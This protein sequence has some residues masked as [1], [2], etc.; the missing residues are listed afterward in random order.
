MHGR[1]YTGTRAVRLA[2]VDRNGR[3]RLDALARFL[4]DVAIEDVQETGW[5][6]PGHLWFV[7]RI[8]V[9]VLAPF[10][11]DRDVVLT[12][13]CSSLAALAA[14]RRWSVRGDRGGHAE[15]DSVWIHLGP[16][17]RPERIENFGVYAESA[18]GRPA[19]TRFEVPEPAADA[20]VTAWPLRAAD[21]D[22]HGHVNNAVHWQAVEHALRLHGFDASRPLVAELDYRDP[23][24]LGDAVELVISGGEP[25]LAA[26]RVGGVTRAAARVTGRGQLPSSASP[27]A[28]WRASL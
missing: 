9:D 15:V 25:L 22:V 24:D 6:T 12:T 14:G 21:E 11:G 13:W 10:L 16:D 27:Q 4:Q 28:A 1:T 5:G 2:D 20:D 18:S 8:R 17:A 7:R 19:S 23:L 3:L 26:L